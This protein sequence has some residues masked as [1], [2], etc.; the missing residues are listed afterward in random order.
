[1]AEWREGQNVP[2]LNQEDR[3]DWRTRQEQNFAV[4]KRQLIQMND[5]IVAQSLDHDRASAT[6]AANLSIEIV[7]ANSH[8]KDD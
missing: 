8:V 7:R 4:N 3:T 1:L 5:C 6:R 2:L